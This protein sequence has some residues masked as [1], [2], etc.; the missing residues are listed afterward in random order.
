[1]TN[2]PSCLSAAPQQA[3]QTRQRPSRWPIATR[4]L[5]ACYT[6]GEATSPPQMTCLGSVALSTLHTRH[7]HSTY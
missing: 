3:L 6:S 7:M 1:M 4:S 5:D 2:I